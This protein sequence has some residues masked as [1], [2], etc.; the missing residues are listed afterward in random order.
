[1]SELRRPSAGWYGVA[2]GIFVLFGIAVPA[3]CVFVLIGSFGG[4]RQFVVPGKANFVW[5]E[6]GTYVLWNELS[7]VYEGRTYSAGETLPDG[8]V[9][10]ITDAADGRALPLTSD[11]STTEQSGGESRRSIGT[12][13]IPRAGS[14]AI[15]V[16]GKFPDRIF[17]VR[18]SVMGRVF[19]AIAGM[20]VSGAVGV[21]GA[22][23][24]VISV[25][26]RRS[27]T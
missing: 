15:E 13:E 11:Q 17:F 25:F 24:L 20:I 5:N 8:M 21:L 3:A 18:K 7:T 23:I 10:T 6:T 26:L 19:A 1:M 12:F 2:F 27:R 14:Y 16:K 4:G 22:L 9:V